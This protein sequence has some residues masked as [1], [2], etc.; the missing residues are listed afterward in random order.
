MFGQSSTCE[1]WA[2]SANRGTW[3]VTILDPGLD[4]LMHVYSSTPRLCRAHMRRICSNDVMATYTSLAWWHP[5]YFSEPLLILPVQ[6]PSLPV[7]SL[8]YFGKAARHN[9]DHAGQHGRV[10]YLLV[11]SPLVSELLQDGRAKLSEMVSRDHFDF[12]QER[13][14]FVSF[15]G[16]P[17]RFSWGTG[18]IDAD[19]LGD[20]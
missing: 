8:V 5:E 12:Q 1:S 3:A 13:S 18:V 17:R 16:E 4:Y 11:L 20:G 19:T 2:I 9:A 15:P 6:L 14:E 7:D 10:L